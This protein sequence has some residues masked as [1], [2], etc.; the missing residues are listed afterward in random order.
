MASGGK[1]RTTMAK[2]NRE[3]KLRERRAD[4][5]ARKYARKHAQQSGPDQPTDAVNEAGAE[6]A[7][8][9]APEQV[10]V[11]TMVGDRPQA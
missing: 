8:G 2:I 4:K 11:A 3:S 7:T 6:D 9:S 1:K 10:P 5:E